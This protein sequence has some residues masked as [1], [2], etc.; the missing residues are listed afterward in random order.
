MKPL[1]LYTYL[2]VIALYLPIAAIIVQ[3]FNDTPYVGGWKG[4]TLR[5]YKVIIG[6][7]QVWNA[8]KNSIMIAVLSAAISIALALPAV[9]S[10]EEHR[11]RVRESLVYMPV[12]MPEIVEA[13]ALLLFFIYIKFPLGAL[14]V[15]IGHTAFNVA[16]AYITLEPVA[17]KART[18]FDVARTLGATPASAFYKAVARVIA[19][20][21]IAAAA[22]AFTLSFTDFIKTLF[23]TGPGF[24][25]L[26]LVVWN[27]ARRPGLTE[28]SSINAVNALASI[29]IITTLTAAMIYL[30]YII[31]TRKTQDTS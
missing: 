17:S 12:I 8:L 11:R 26:P 25:T 15:L 21:V 27:K 14:S 22:I 1:R 30:A 2:V 28:Y 4:F 16:Y 10:E 5:W 29:I 31:K 13:I 24:Y 6:D 7:A 20:A 3:S 18:Y 9:V 23:T 19:P